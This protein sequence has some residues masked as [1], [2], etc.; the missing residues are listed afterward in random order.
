MVP[1]GFD[2]LVLRDVPEIVVLCLEIPLPQLSM[3]ALLNDGVVLQQH[4]PVVLLEHRQLMSQSL[5]VLCQ[6][7]NLPRE[8]L[9]PILTFILDL[10]HSLLD[11]QFTFLLELL[12]HF[13]QLLLKNDLI[14]GHLSSHRFFLSFCI[15]F[16]GNIVISGRPEIL[17]G[18]V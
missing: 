18:E 1:L 6:Q 9:Y 12:L 4:L 2:G 14:V 7:L 8:H 15:S 16:E 13:A 10:L 11:A 5:G 3:Y 17:V